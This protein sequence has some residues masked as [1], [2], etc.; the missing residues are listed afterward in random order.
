MDAGSFFHLVAKCFSG[1][2]QW[3]SAFI[4][5]WADTHLQ[6]TKQMKATF[7]GV[8]RKGKQTCHS[9]FIFRCSCAG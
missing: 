9:K 3:H 7:N 1:M 8:L 5:V 4:L 2:E 6:I